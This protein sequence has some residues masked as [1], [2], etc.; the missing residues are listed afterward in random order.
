MLR[1][2]YHPGATLFAVWQ[3]T[4]SAYETGGVYGGVSDL[5]SLLALPPENVLLLK[6]NYWLSR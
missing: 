5:R 2:E 4:R 6:V 1:W 3:H